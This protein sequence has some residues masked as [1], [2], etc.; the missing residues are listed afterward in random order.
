MKIYINVY[1]YVY[2][3]DTYICTYAYIYTNI[4]GHDIYVKYRK[5]IQIQMHI[6]KYTCMYIYIHVDDYD[7][8]YTHISVRADIY[9][10]IY[11]CIKI[12]I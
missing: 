2:T 8:T 10:Y 6:S 11:V 5:H 12:H 7:N 4:H 9:L 3:R 1:T